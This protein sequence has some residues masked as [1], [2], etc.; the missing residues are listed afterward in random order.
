MMYRLSEKVSNVNVYEKL[1]SQLTYND[2]LLQIEQCR[3]KC[4]EGKE[5]INVK[6]VTVGQV[7]E[8]CKIREIKAGE[9]KIQWR[10]STLKWLRDGKKKTLSVRKEEKYWKEGQN[11][12]SLDSFSTYL[13]N[14]FQNENMCAKSNKKTHIFQF[15]ISSSEWRQSPS[16]R[17]KA[18]SYCPLGTQLR[19]FLKLVCEL[20]VQIVT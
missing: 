17:R 20:Y 5:R 16:L 9:K 15:F 6:A 2:L 13:Q 11:L 14:S 8:I 4:K 10:Y 3:L 19:S 18:D 12:L 7:A 1:G